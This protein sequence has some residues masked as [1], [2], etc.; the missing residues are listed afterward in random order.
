VLVTGADGQ[1]GGTLVQ[2]LPPGYTISALSRAGLDIC[3]AA[4]VSR[5]V[6]EF[7]PSLIVNAAA[8]TAVDKAETN[9][10]QA[11]RV[12]AAGPAN[13]ARSAKAIAGCRLLHVS[14]DYVFSGDLSRAY[15]A[16]DETGP[17]SVY[18][19]TKLHGE[20]NVLGELGARAV[21]LRVAW[22]YSPRGAN[23]LLTMLRLM[24]ERRSVSVVADQIG[25]PTAAISIAGAIW[26]FAGK[27]QLSGV[28]HW[29]ESGVASWYDFAVAIAEESLARGLL[30]DGVAV[31][32]ISTDEYPTA[33]KRPRF[34][35]LD[36]RATAAAL[37]LPQVHW[38]TRLR[39]VLDEIKNA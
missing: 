12:N 19:A 20:K 34:S 5:V 31:R 29:A 26:A 9:V 11:A 2:T 18:G 3:D 15:L 13:L 22:V 16:S 32:P 39:Q 21:V 23:F 1:L 30:P 38:R 8:Y 14:T 33:A 37:G 35:L 10:E 7:Q 27:S 17:A 36:S 28:H 25:C 24:R 6:T 4:A